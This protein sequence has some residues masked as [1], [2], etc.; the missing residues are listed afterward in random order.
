MGNLL[1]T[2]SAVFTTKIQRL[3]NGGVRYDIRARGVP[4]SKVVPRAASPADRQAAKAEMDAKLKQLKELIGV[5][6]TPPVAA[7]PVAAPPE[8]ITANR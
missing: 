2:N 6:T 4:W 7:P 3:L 5:A 1:K 8:A